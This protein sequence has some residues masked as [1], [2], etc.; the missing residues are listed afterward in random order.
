MDGQ[1][2]PGFWK[3]QFTGEP[4][5]GQNRYDVIFGI[6]MPILCLLMDPIVFKGFGGILSYW[7]GMAYAFIGAEILVL[8]FWLYLRGLLGNAALCF[9]GPLLAGG[10]FALGLH[11][12]M[13]PLTLRGMLL[14]I[15]FLGLT[16]FFT[17]FVYFRNAW[18]AWTEDCD[19]MGRATRISILLA[20]M[21]VMI[22]PS[23]GVLYGIQNQSLEDVAQAVREGRALRGWITFG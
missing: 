3:R 20:G 6:V 19:P 7:S 11:A 12:F 21:A 1:P 8:A 9:A 15:G 13:L 4:T 2:K 16:P 18:R 5:K 17:S 14:L 22:L 10:V 23:L